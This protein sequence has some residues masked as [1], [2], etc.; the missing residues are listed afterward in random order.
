MNFFFRGSIVCLFL[1]LLMGCSGKS[2]IS[3]FNESIDYS[4]NNLWFELP[5]EV[6]EDVDVFY[7]LPTCIWDW[8]D[9]NGDVC[10]FADVNNEQQREAMQ[11]SYELAR[12]IFADGNGNFFAPYY[13]QISLESWIEGDEI[14]EQRFPI[15]MEDILGAF[16]YFIDNL[17]NERPFVL[18]GFSQGGK[19]VVELLKSMDA[20]VYERMVAAYVVGYRV[21]SDD[22]SSYDNIVEAECADDFGVTICYNSVE[23]VES[24][25][26]VLSPS[27]ICINPVNWSVDAT[28]AHLNDSVT[29][30]VDVVNKVLLLDGL[31]SDYYYI[32][33]LSELFAK[34]NYHLQELSFYA[35]HLNDNVKLR[36]SNYKNQ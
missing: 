31:D 9:E 5:V 12:D 27:A 35:Q 21:T 24:V 32:P 14:V 15:A 25:A 8:E 17:S 18:A 30:R 22:I 16:N 34:G 7:I 29:V 33:L 13:R 3:F 6:S 10:H 23:S 4:D 11:G 2:D 28:V 36:I 19:G 26:P 1:V 20:Q